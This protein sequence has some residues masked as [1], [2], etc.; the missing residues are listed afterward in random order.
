VSGDPLDDLFARL[1]RE[2]L[3][4]DR[5]YNRALSAL[6]ALV[7][8]PPPPLAVPAAP[9][10]AAQLPVLN[11]RWRVLPDEPPVFDR[12]LKGRL[13][14]AIWRVVAP[15][16]ERQQ[17]FNST[18]V[19]HLNRTD[20]SLRR[21]QAAGEA[22]IA[23]AQREMA[24]RERFNVEL[25][26]YLRTVTAFVDTRDRAGGA[27]AVRERLALVEE[28]VMA[29][30]R[31]VDATASGSAASPAV[32]EPQGGSDGERAAAAAAFSG[33]VGGAD[34]L[35][36]EARYRG[37]ETDIRERVTEYVPLFRGAHDVVDV[38]CGRGELLDALRAA[39]V[40]ARGVDSNTAMVEHCRGRG[41]DVVQ[42]D[43]LGFLNS[44]AD[45][46]LGGLVA[47]QVVEHFEPGYLVRFLETAFHKLRPGAALVL[48][49]INP[50]CWLA[51]FEAYL[52]DLTHQRALHPD[53][54]RYLVEANGFQQ[55]DVRYR[56]PVPE[57]H[58][59]ERA[60][61]TGAPDANVAALAAAINGH[62]EKLNAR[63][64]SATDYAVIARR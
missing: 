20:A 48:E 42:G 52:R 54:L 58:R 31:A 43:A 19:D 44:A 51:F 12:S 14:G 16:F 5:A 39:G 61:L 21:Q 15:L 59:L 60:A 46:S 64:F 40:S 25:L 3:D 17:Q 10:D 53:T 36:F 1:E 28:R 22:L 9:V 27:A 55:V 18:L 11:D 57:A 32:A 8:E 4:A 26:A 13:R 6:D 49:T 29:L 2:R 50:A 47:I 41:L 38:G 56:R 34:Y 24:A 23:L 35:G 45:G 7:R 37:A 63:L 33:S 30:K 62:A